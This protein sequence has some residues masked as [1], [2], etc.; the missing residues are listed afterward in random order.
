MH[1]LCV[2]HK[3]P[4]SLDITPTLD[5]FQSFQTTLD[6]SR[7]YDIMSFSCYRLIISTVLYLILSVL[8]KVCLLFRLIIQVG[9]ILYYFKLSLILQKL[10]LVFLIVK[11]I[12]ISI[13]F[14]S[15]KCLS[16]PFNLVIINGKEEQKIKRILDSY[17]YWKFHT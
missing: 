10:Y 11:L 13:D 12:A 17:Q 5:S 16:P 14:I 9:P 2:Y 7:P 1:V 15:R 4:M 8:T 6:Y 3:E